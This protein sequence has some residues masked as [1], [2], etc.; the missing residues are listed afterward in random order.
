VNILV[1]GKDGQLGKYIMK[2]VTKTIQKN[3]FCFVGREE[4]D[5]SNKINIT[6]YFKNNSFDI[7]INC[8]AY[9]AV[10]KAEKNKSLANQINHLAVLQLANIA[11]RK[12]IKLIHI[13]TDYVFDGKTN[14]PYLE[15]DPANP[16]N[17]YG[18]TKLAGE[19]AI[20]KIMPI[21]SYIIRTSWV[22]SGYG[23]NFVKTM[24]KLGK[25]RSKL[26]VVCDQI[27]SPTYAGDLAE[28]ILN[29]V[30]NEH[31]QNNNHPSKIYHYS[32]EGSVS[33]YQFA[34]EIFKL[35]K[36]E[37]QVNPVLSDEY[38]TPAKRPKNT[39]LGMIRTT[40][41]LKINP[42]FWKKSLKIFLTDETV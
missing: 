39:L 19:I 41:A 10:D 2:K 29:I 23:N 6:N 26:N 13:S 35:A 20:R 12:S 40:K 33:W 15:N 27:S 14:K 11:Q 18:K 42:I 7:I 25:E 1:T 31:Y 28:V 16:I 37:C 17:T 8:A 9:T 32:N 34:K 36:I 24:L 3:N 38:P 5:L 21:N 22:Y 4:L 30:K